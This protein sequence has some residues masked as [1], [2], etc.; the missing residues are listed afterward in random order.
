MPDESAMARRSPERIGGEIND[1][2]S[3]EI[4][5]VAGPIQLRLRAQ[6]TPVGLLAFGVMMSGIVASA[7]AIVWAARRR[8]RS[9][10]PPP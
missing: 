8:R 1:I 2:Q 9:N 7:S 6:M 3:A 4:E 5:L 10:S